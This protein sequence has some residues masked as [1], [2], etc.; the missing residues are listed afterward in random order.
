LN[1]TYS[2]GDLLETSQKY[3][4]SPF[5]GTDF[6]NSYKIDRKTV[7]N[8]LNS[9]ITK[10]ITLSQ[11]I[12]TLLPSE[13][14]LSNTSITKFT[15]ETLLIT[16]LNKSQLTLNDKVILSKLLKSFEITKKIFTE[17]DFNQNTF[18]IDHKNLRNYILFSLLCGKE[19][20]NSRNLK[21]LNTVLKLNDIISS[22]VVQISENS[23]SL[24]AFYAISLE[25]SS[26][27]TIKEL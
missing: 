12:K 8:Q 23:N 14:F 1:Y 9:K 27:N 26:I 16:F 21:Y 18:S 19:F 7:L 6:L 11:L 25:L 4:M 5:H 22:K 20:E 2:K 3:Q 13:K 10:K 15:T 17:Y 24:L